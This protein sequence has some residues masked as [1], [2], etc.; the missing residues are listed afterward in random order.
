DAPDCAHLKTQYLQGNHDWLSDLTRTTG[1]HRVAN[2]DLHPWKMVDSRDEKVQAIL[3]RMAEHPATGAVLVTSM[4]MATITGLDYDRLTG[5]V[6][7]ATGKP[8]LNVPGDGLNGDWLDGYAAMLK[9][10]AKGLPLTGAAPQPGTVAVVGYLFDRNEGDHLANL[11]ELERLLGALGLRVASV[12]LSGGKVADLARVREA[13]AIIS[14]PYGRDA[15]RILGE[16]LGVPVVST[17]LPLGLGG[18]ERWLRQVAEALGVTERLQPLLDAELGRA[19]PR[20]EWVVPYHLLHRKLAF[21]GEPHLGLAMGGL[22]EELGME[23]EHALVLNRPAHAKALLEQLGPSRVTCDPKHE[24]LMTSLRRLME[25]GRCDLLVTNSIG[26]M[27]GP[28]Q[29]GVVE[30]GFPSFF[31]HALEDRPFLFF[32]GALVLAERMV[33]ALRAAELASFD[34]RRR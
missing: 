30:L 23:L 16:R 5:A 34:G 10:L 14:L 1:L 2:T 32:R 20:L 26:V 18:T 12:W 28:Q 3:Q 6:A 21:V 22:V 8:V 11:S 33:N 31:T 15:A 29:A 25:E 27:P 24:A 13:S 17:G 9:A 19:V 7:G 4:P